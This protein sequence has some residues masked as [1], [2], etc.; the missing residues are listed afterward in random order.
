M[1]NNNMGNN[2]MGNN[3]FNNTN[4]N[5][6]NRGT[7]TGAVNNQVINEYLAFQ[8]SLENTKIQL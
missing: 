8:T 7:V 6:F 3:L 1:G 5:M 2:T 4:N